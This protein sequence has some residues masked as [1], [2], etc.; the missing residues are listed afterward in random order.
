MSLA[1]T[2]TRSLLAFGASLGS[3]KRIDFRLQLALGSSFRMS[4]EVALARFP[5][6]GWIRIAGAIPSR[7]SGYYPLAPLTLLYY[8]VAGASVIPTASFSHEGA[9]SSFFNSATIHDKHLQV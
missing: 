1:L 2:N 8:G 9:F 6:D 4:C 7:R 5:F 3:F